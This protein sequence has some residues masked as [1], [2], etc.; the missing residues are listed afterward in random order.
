MAFTDS[1][2]LTGP[3][4]YFAVPAVVLE[5]RAD[6]VSEIERQQWQAIV[7]GIAAELDWALPQFAFKF[8]PK[9][10]T[11]AFTAPLDQLYTATE[12]NEWAWST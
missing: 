1:R 12:V 8:H 5:A 10:A 11:L 6:A 3:N 4:V 7:T 2:R 9:G